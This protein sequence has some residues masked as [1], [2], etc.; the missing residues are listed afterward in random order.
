MC[1]TDDTDTV[2]EIGLNR[3]LKSIGKHLE[4]EIP[5]ADSSQKNHQGPINIFEDLLGEL[6]T[7]TG[8][9]QWLI[10]SCL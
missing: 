2:F 3:A 9:A 4:P 7:G 8:R 5:R 10:G 6:K 1:H